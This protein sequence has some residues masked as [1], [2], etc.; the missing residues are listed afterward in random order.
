MCRRSWPGCPTSGLGK[1]PGVSQDWGSQTGVTPVSRRQATSREQGKR[2]SS[3]QVW[4]V[5]RH[6]YTFPGASHP[7]ASEGPQGMAL[8]SYGSWRGSARTLLTPKTCCPLG[9]RPFH[10]SAELRS[11]VGVGAD[12]CLPCSSFTKGQS[13]EWPTGSVHVRVCARVCVCVCTAQRG[14]LSTAKQPWGSVCTPSP[15]GLALPGLG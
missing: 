9:P 2:G 5:L 10:A 4:G 7:R 12:M 8:L 14:A 15:R 6:R 13:Q 11:W 3:I 1:A